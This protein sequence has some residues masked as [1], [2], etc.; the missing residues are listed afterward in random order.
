MGVLIPIFILSIKK[1]RTI[2]LITI[3]AVIAV[4]GLWLNRYLIVIPTLETPF[5]PIQ[6]TREEFIHYTATWIEWSLSLAGI[7]AFF[8]FFTLIMKFI[9]IIPISGIIKGEKMIDNKK[10][11][12]KTIFE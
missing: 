3:S 8:L 10:K 11:G 7:A 6:D 12:K 4:A 1:L 5:L 2:K 9:P